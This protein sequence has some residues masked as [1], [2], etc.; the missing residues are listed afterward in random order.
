MFLIY[1]PC[2]HRN[3]A[4]IALNI[5]LCFITINMFCFLIHLLKLI[6]YDTRCIP[7]FAF[8]QSLLWVSDFPELLP[9]YVPQKYHLSRPDIKVSFLVPKH[10]RCSNVWSIVSWELLSRFASNLFFF[11]EIVPHSLTYRWNWYNVNIQYSFL[12]L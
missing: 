8:P 7:L 5:F 3:L 4:I 1:L 10:R 11:E 12:F 9:R 6:K 2:L